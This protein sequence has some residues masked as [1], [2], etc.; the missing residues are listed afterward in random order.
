NAR[1]AQRRDSV[2]AAKPPPP[3]LDPRPPVAGR[4]P[5]AA[6]DTCRC[7]IRGTIEAQTERPLSSPLEVTLT[8]RG[9]PALVSHVRL[10]MGSPR[11]FTFERVPCGQ[12]VLD[13]A[14]ASGRRFTVVRPEE[15]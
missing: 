8:V 9:A 2:K 10:D 14:L 4:L 12:R 15:L 7:R 11:E 5:G 6:A 1:A 3:T 13:I